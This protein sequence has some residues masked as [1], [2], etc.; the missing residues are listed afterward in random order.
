SGLTNDPTPTF[1]FHASESGAGFE[2]SIDTGVADF[3]PCSD[4][5][6]HTPAG[7]LADGAYTFRVRATDSVGN[8]GAATTRSFVVDT[9]APRPPE[10]TA[11]VPPSPANENPP[12]LVGSAPAGSTVRI[13]GSA[14]CSGSPIAT[15]TAAQLADGVVLSVAD[16]SVTRFAATDTSSA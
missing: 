2:C 4:I 10:L 11:T 15:V 6:S 13:Y 5:G 7:P 12:K 9:T 8:R 1:A 14:D 3:L 16:D